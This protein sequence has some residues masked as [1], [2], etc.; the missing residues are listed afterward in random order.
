MKTYPNG[1]HVCIWSRQHEWG[2]AETKTV[3]DELRSKA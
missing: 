1:D 3:I 2:L